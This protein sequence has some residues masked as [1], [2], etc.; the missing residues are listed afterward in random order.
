MSLKKNHK[1]LGKTSQS[2]KNKAQNLIEF[3]F[4]LPLLIF[5]TLAIFEI[6]LFW[7]EVNAIYNL[8]AEINANAALSDV[9][10]MAM[11]DVCPAALKALE[12]LEEKD[13]TISLNNPSYTKGIAKSGGKDLG[14]EPFAL[15][16]YTSNNIT[17]GGV[18]KPQ[19]TLW[20]DC[21]SPFEKGITTQIEFYHKTM[22]MKATIPRFD[23]SEGIEIIP[24]NIFIASPKLNTLRHY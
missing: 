1:A 24:E 11:G 17:V 10:G 14:T 4:I 22:V 21:R 3:M 15:Y 19:I 9:S 18:T 23:K 2:S 5:I 13:S 6:A 8:N 16:K 20:V 12:I 7:Q